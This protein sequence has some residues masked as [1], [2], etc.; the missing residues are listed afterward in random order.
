MKE[1]L[2]VA[3]GG[4]C[5]L[6]RAVAV[7]AGAQVGRIPVGPVVLGVRLLVAA[8]ALLRLAE[9]IRQVCRVRGSRPCRLPLAPGKPRPDLLQKP[10][11][12]VRIAERGIRAVGTALWIGARGARPGVGDKA[13]AEASA[14]VVE[15][16]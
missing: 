12:A 14:G 6:F 8:V 7:L 1:F 4:G 16:L 13:A 11:V 10:D 3:I 5:R 9:K 2:H 15:H